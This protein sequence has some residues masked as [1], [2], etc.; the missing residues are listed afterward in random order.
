MV[1]MN[2]CNLGI[3]NDGVIYFSQLILTVKSVKMFHFLR[4]MG[5]YTCQ[6]KS[7][8]LILCGFYKTSFCKLAFSVGLHLVYTTDC[9]FLT[10]IILSLSIGLHLK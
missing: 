5:Q 7:K 4:I 10:V 3:S 8:I 6:K 1:A 9:D 2:V